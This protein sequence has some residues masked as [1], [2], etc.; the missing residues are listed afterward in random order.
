MA[1]RLK[2][3]YKE[4]VAPALKEKF[5][6]GNSMQIPK[7]EKIVLNMGLGRLSDAGKDNKVIDEAPKDEDNRIID[8]KTRSQIHK[9]LLET[10]KQA[11]E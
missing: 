8:F 11:Y 1:P 5:S 6:Y 9:I 7:V 3:F 10:S 2:E 4:S